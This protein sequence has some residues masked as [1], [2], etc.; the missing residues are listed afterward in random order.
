[1]IMQQAFRLFVCIMLLVF[2]VIAQTPKP[3][4][5]LREQ[6]DI[7]QQWLKLR[8]ERALP[9]LMRRHGVQM[10][11]V[12]CREYNEDP[13]FYSLVSP[14]VFAAR[15]R[16][17]YVFFDRGEER[18]IERLALGGGSNGG[19][20]TVYRDP[21]VEGREIYGEGQW[22][23]LRKLIDER[24]PASIA[25]NI[26]H[27]HAFSDGLSAGER[28]KLE[29]VLGT[30]HLKRLV[31][32]ENLALEYVSIR[33]PE[34]LPVYRQMM[35]TVHSLISRAFSNEVITPGK[36]TDQD[37]VWW[38]RQ[39]VNDLGLGTW[40]QPSVRVQKPSNAGV[41]L[42][43]ENAAVVIERG[44]VLHVDFGITAMRLNTD[45]Q[46]MGYVLREGER[47]APAGIRRAL[48][49]ANRLQDILME[50]MKPG[51]SGNEVLADALS[52]MRAEGIKG[53]IYTHPI[54]DHGHGAGPLIGLWDR[55]QGVPGRGDALILPST[56]FSIELQAT[57]PVPE[58]GGKELWVGQEEDAALDES[59]KISWV[60]RR[61]TEYHLVK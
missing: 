37:V 21:E 18:G 32:A 44:D 39:R 36:T 54:G 9:K 58:W 11:L 52:Q 30:E 4:P 51:R 1:M 24:K 25:I 38:L 6:A 50:R 7:Q 43:A 55:Q 3:L 22:A 45:T 46:H 60:L 42:L 2:P 49:N 59:G 10:W 27:T 23:L 31:R 15:R 14:T 5:P 48:A 40:F 13:V 26:S 53:T 29:S 12:I 28:E 35:E 16:T 33:L 56:W 20:Y 34:M 19:L 17:I 41:N 57:T 47:D 8:L 61:Q